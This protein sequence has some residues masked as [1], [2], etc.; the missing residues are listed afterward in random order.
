MRRF[1]YL[2]RMKSNKIPK[3]DNGERISQ[4]N[5]GWSKKM[6]SKDLQKRC[7][8]YRIAEEQHFFRMKD[9]YSTRTVL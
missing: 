7:K 5:N 1:G 9:I 2:K 8:A 6:I 3:N 4:G